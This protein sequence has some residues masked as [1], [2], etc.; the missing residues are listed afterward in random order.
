MILEASNTRTRALASLK[1][2]SNVC[3]GY[4][5][6]FLWHQ[7][8]RKT[9]KYLFLKKKHINTYHY[10]TVIKKKESQC[11]IFRYGKITFNKHQG[12]CL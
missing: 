6:C 1:S 7:L 3:I 10:D 8:K 12:L 2:A 9:Y 4:V 11:R 5:S